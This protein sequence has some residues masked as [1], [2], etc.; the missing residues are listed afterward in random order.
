MN[1]DIRNLFYEIEIIKNK[2]ENLAQK[3]RVV[4]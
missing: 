1:L 2:F 3:K 4:R